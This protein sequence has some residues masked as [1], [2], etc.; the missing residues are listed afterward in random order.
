[1]EQ[2]YKWK[3]CKNIFNIKCRGKLN[4]LKV[5]LALD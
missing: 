5:L 2:M 1:M 4:K 3:I